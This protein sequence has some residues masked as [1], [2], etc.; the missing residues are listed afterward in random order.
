MCV[1]SVSVPGVSDTGSSRVRFRSALRQ[2]VAAS[3]GHE[4]CAINGAAHDA[5][6]Y[7]PAEL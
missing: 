3:R 4:R 2:L 7:V 6:A 1:L 5:W